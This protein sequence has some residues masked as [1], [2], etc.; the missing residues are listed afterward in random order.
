MSCITVIGWGRRAAAAPIKLD[1][2]PPKSVLPTAHSLTSARVILFTD[3][4]DELSKHV[5]EYENPNTWGKRTALLYAQIKV[6]ARFTTAAR[7][8]RRT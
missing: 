8:H 6:L 4:H 1:P 3:G 2:P 7:R 5:D